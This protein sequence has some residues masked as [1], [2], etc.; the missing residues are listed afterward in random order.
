MYL[1][2]TCHP[3]T[4]NVFPALDT[5]IV[6][7][8]I[9]GCVCVTWLIQWYAR[10][11]L[12]TY[13]IGLFLMC[14]TTYS[15]VQYE[16][17]TFFFGWVISFICL[18]WLVWCV[19]RH[20]LFHMCFLKYDILLCVKW[21][22]HML[23]MNHA[24]QMTSLGNPSIPYAYQSHMPGLTNHVPYA[25]LNT[26][27]RVA[28][29]TFTYEWGMSLVVTNLATC[30]G[31]NAVCCSVSQCISGEFQCVAVCFSVLI[32]GGLFE[33]VLTN[34]AKCTCPSVPS[35][36]DPCACICIHAHTH[37][38]TRTHTHTH[39]HTYIHKHAHT[40]THT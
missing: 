12:S 6:R 30:T 32:V 39:T 21:I 26:N 14:D 20:D 13:V 22:I 19:Q 9:P 2:S 11:N 18:T 27:E 36:S 24:C 37:T 5:V 29:K 40:L 33:K 1:D 10:H 7:S 38:H 28:S 34:L 8:H 31:G 16:F 17:V 4:E 35:V 25:R 23:N 15:Y 3:V